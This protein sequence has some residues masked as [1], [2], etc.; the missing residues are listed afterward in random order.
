[1]HPHSIIFSADVT[2]KTGYTFYGDPHFW[3][4]TADQVQELESLLQKYL[5]VHPPLSDKPVRN[6]REYGCQYHGV[7]KN[8]RNAICLKAFCNPSRFDR[9]WEKEIISVRDGASCYFQ[10]F[11][12]PVTREFTGLKYNGLA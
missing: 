10:V 1:M 4:P 8:D 7:T 6:V 5:D 11:F 9:R 12:N 3:T 2:E